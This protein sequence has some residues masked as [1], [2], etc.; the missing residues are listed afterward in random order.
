MFSQRQHFGQQ[1]QYNSA[2]S[3]LFIMNADCVFE[4]NNAQQPQHQPK[5][6]I[7]Y[8]MCP[9]NGFLEEWIM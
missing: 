8:S 1:E 4:R 5:S 3:Q 6:A 2:D 9:G 7:W